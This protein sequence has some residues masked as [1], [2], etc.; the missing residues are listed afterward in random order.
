MTRVP[1]MTTLKRLLSSLL[2]ASGLT[3]V[4]VGLSHALGFTVPGMI[5]SIAVIGALLYAGGVWFGAPPG[6]PAPA[7]AATVLVFDRDLRVVTGPGTGAPL[8]KRFPAPL[9]PEIEMR[10]R[11]A[12]RG[13][14]T[15]FTCELEGRRLL[16]DVSPV[17]SASGAVL[18]GVLMTGA[19]PAIPA[20][21]APAPL[22]S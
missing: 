13:E 18:Y 8:I 10:C 2:L 6:I 21:Q 5:A 1:A 17:A 15:Q 4:F 14:S 19:G 3:L 22:F 12:L 16:F 11:A 20:V 7:G 9:R